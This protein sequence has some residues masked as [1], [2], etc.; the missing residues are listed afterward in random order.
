M[1]CGTAKIERM[2][3]ME[4]S[5][6]RYTTI[7]EWFT[8]HSRHDVIGALKKRGFNAS[9]H[10]SLQSACNEIMQIVPVSTSVGIPGS[11][12]VRELGLIERFVER[13]TTVYQHWKENLTEQT[14]QDHRRLEGTADY[15]ITSANAI[16]I[17]GD[18]I[19]IDGVGN[20]VADTVFGPKHVIIVAG[21]NKLVRSIDEGIRRSKEV[22][23][24][25][26]AK[27]VNADTPCAKTG[28]CVDCH[29]EHRICR[30]I[31]IIQYRPFQTDMTVILINSDLGF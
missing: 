25:M 14:D 7:K 21:L 26:N 28:V 2:T 12:T 24:V 20:R 19:N 9:Y 15:Y 1:I 22:A 3:F 27:R 5:N 30:V 18:I 6:T 17:Q 8:E 16:T 4:T 10:G 11:V 23:A 29:A 31:S 13:G